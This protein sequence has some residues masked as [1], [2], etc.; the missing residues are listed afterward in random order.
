MMLATSNL[1]RFNPRPRAGGDPSCMTTSSAWKRFQ[2]TPPCGGR[3]GRWQCFP[4][5]FGFNPRPRAG[6]DCRRQLRRFFPEG[7]NPRPRAGGDSAA[8]ANRRPAEVSIHAPVR[9]ATGCTV[10]RQGVGVFQSTPP[11]G[12][13]LIFL[14]IIT[15]IQC[16]NPRPRAGGDQSLPGGPS[17]INCFNPRPRAGG[18]AI[19]GSPCSTTQSFNPRP[20]AGGD[21]IFAVQDERQQGFN[22]RPRAG[23][24]CRR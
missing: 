11:C 7:F 1:S 24:D 5:T 14:P 9:G 8:C 16:F 19:T 22:P 21:D 18:D 3:R 20:R 23:G 17:W 13:R 12:G 2:S 4:A 10:C 6:G 15:P